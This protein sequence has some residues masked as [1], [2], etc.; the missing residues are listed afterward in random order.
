MLAIPK[1]DQPLLDAATA[2]LHDDR[3]TIR[4]AIQQTRSLVSSD[5]IS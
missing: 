3:Q 4:E 5:R 1:C 2:I